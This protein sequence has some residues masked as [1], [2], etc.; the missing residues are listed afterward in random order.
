MRSASPRTVVVAISVLKLCG[1]TEVPIPAASLRVQ[2]FHD[3]SITGSMEIYQPVTGY[4]WGTIAC[5]FLHL[6]DERR[7]TARKC[8]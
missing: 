4:R 1:I 3:L 5:P 8:L 6:P 7:P 2:A